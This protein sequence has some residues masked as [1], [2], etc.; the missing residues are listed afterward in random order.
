MHLILLI[1]YFTKMRFSPKKY[2]CT[3]ALLTKLVLDNF[4][5]KYYNLIKNL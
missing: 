5:D 3:S 4:I 2:A 1:L